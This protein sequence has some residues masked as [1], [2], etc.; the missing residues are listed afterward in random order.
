L[1]Q[2]GYFGT[3][4]G[5]GDGKLN[6]E[7]I[8]ERVAL[9]LRRTVVDA[10]GRMPED[11]CGFNQPDY[12][13]F[14]DLALTEEFLEDAAWRLK[15]YQGQLEDAG[16]WGEDLENAQP[17]AAKPVKK[18]KPHPGS[19]KAT[20]VGHA[21]E[22]TFKGRIGERVA[23][24]KAMGAKGAR[25]PDGEWYWTLDSGRALANRHELE[26]GLGFDLSEVT[27]VP[28]PA[29]APPPAPTLRLVRSQGPLIKIFSPYNAELVQLMRSLTGFGFNPEDKSRELGVNIGT[30]TRILDV[31]YWAREQGWQVEDVTNIELECVNLTA[32]ASD[33]EATKTDFSVASVPGQEKL[34]VVPYPYQR[35]G[36]TFLN[37]A[38]G[39]GIVG[40]EM[41]LGKTFQA[42]GWVV[43][44]EKR[45]LVV[46]PKSFMFG[47]ANEVAKFS[48]AS[49]Q[50]LGPK[51]TEFDQAQFTIVNYE[52]AG[53][54]DFSQL[55]YDTLIIDES[56]LIKN[57]KTL[58]YQVIA[59]LAKHA[60]HV[61][62]LSGTAIVN[63]PAE[64][65]TQLNLVAPGLTGGWKTFTERFC[66]GHHDGYGWRADGA[67]NIEELVKL[68]APVYIRR[69]K[70]DVLKELPAKIRQEIVVDGIRVQVATG[71]NALAAITRTKYDVAL[72]KI[73]AT[74]EFAEGIVENGEKVIIFSD[75]V[76]PVE[77][78]AEHFGEQAIAYLAELDPAERA[79]A[80][81]R[82]QEDPN[83]KV[84]VATT[85]IASV[86]LTLTAASHVVFND[87][88]WTPGSLLQAEDRAHRVGQKDVV[89]I[90]RIT[91]AHDFDRSI[92]SLLTSKAE[93]LKAVLEG[94]GS[95]Y[96]QA[97]R[98]DAEGSILTDMVKRFAPKKTKTAV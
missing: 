77:R 59:E 51:P 54:H 69:N 58:R 98:E 82:F 45:A 93:I 15:K 60:Q 6:L 66:G 8:S 72:A 32:A 34:K 91:A 49:S 47:W 90:Y 94:R 80:Q 39:R 19:A 38:G 10:D 64:F 83:V 86:A 46:C 57:S 55:R 68:V 88:P 43:T 62:L 30:A 89:N 96:T 56:H 22:F 37:K 79:E 11:F 67:T 76:E 71:D 53:K 16:L 29:V 1:T 50:V 7:L 13:W 70:A 33:L 41:G 74:I 4:L 35:A 31:I 25:R 78:I 18:R 20:Q 52:S 24:L 61:I 2:R 75:Y 36:I 14:R 44:N 81:R 73:G 92:S 40:D 42:L 65:F 26:D 17:P 87:M 27:A 23:A 28:A 63:R 5:M 3:I 9:L 12:L 85:K 95:D 21:V 97:Q 48:Y 84:F